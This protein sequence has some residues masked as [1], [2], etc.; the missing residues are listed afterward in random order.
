VAAV[1]VEVLR[2]PA[3]HAGKVYR[4]TGPQALTLA[5]LAD[6]VTRVTGSPLVYHAETLPEA[7][8]SR[9]VYGAE[10]W[11]VEAWVSTYTAIAAGEVAEVSDDV[12]R[13]TGR[14]ATPLERLLTAP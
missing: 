13:L 3:A 2:A 12:V 8:A 1:A 9:A 7:Y 5:E 11:Q 14:P 10:L 6:T 4:L